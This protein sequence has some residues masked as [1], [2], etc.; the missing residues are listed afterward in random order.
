M[1]DDENETKVF[2]FAGY[3]TLAKQQE[4]EELIEK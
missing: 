3:S 1:S 4:K 2:M